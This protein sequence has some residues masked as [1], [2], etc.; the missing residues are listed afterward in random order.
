MHLTRDAFSATVLLLL[1]VGLLMVFSAGMTSRPSTAEQADLLRHLLFLG[2]ALTI[3]TA[4][5][6]LPARFWRSAAPIVFASTLLLLIVVLIPG[7]GTMVNGARR[8]LRFGPASLQPSEV[9]KVA[10]PLFLCWTTERRRDRSGRIT[11]VVPPLVPVAATVFLVLQQP[12]L[13]TAL[14][15]CLTAAIC[16]FVCGWPMRHF[17]LAGGC[18]APLAAGVVVLRP[19]QWAR[20]NGFFATW[21]DLNLAPYQVRQSLATLGGGGWSGVG[22]GRGTQKLSFLPEPNTDFVFA[23]IGEELGL[24]GTFGVGLLWLAL[25]VLGLR[26]L[27]HLSTSSFEYTLAVTLAAQ[28]VLQAAINAGVATALLP[29][30]GI[31]HPLISYGGSSLVV[32]LLSVGIVISASRSPR[33]VADD[34]AH[35]QTAVTRQATI[36]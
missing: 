23:V 25:F 10:L 24:L 21:R 1:S 31:P 6:L 3:G 11:A 22:L 9:A 8:W 34:D 32:S 16:L 26:L 15:L 12:D 33:Q 20:I 19:Y 36:D 14:F 17:V 30:T 7:V 2:V 28:L 4:A 27:C 29:A 35:G 5:A 18:V 13:G